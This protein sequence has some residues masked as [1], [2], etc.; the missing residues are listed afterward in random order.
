LDIGRR[1]PYKLLR[2]KSDGISARVTAITPG[3]NGLS[4]PEKERVL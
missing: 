2:V 4:T 3:M 1:A